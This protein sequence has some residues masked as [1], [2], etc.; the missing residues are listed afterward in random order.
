MYFLEKENEKMQNEK[1]FRK[2]QN[3]MLK[4]EDEQFLEKTKI[5]NLKKIK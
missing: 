5:E 2:N 1:F 3:E 4:K